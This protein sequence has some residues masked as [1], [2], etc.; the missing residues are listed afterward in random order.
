MASKRSKETIA[1]EIL[2][3]CIGGACKTR[4]V[5]KTNMNF[6]TGGSY[7]NKLI[8]YGLLQIINGDLTIYETTE[9]GQEILRGLK[10]IQRDIVPL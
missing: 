3:L 9:K 2:E 8:R 6:R 1:A 4:I 10:N 5:Y 7:I